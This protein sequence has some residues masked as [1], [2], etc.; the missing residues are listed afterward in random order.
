MKLRAIVLAAFAALAL[1]A[2][3]AASASAHEYLVEGKAIK[4]AALKSTSETGTVNRLHGVPQGV[5]STIL[6]TQRAYTGLTLG[7]AGVSGGTLSFSTCTVEK[8]AGCKVAEPIKTE[9]AGSL[10]E[11]GGA[12]VSKFA[13]KVAGT[14]FTEITFENEASCSL[15]AKKFKVEGNQKCEL[16]SAT[17]EKAAHGITCAFTGSE[18]SL[19]GKKA[20]FES[21]EAKL[22]IESG[23]FAAGGTFGAG[24]GWSA[25]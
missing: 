2:T 8:P 21:N 20:E 22:E 23:E 25:L 19:G 7:A 15:K 16:P 13:P 5:S 3:A 12:L 24:V 10:E 1:S 9:V 17:S 11:I 14:P 18:L 4:S 6:C